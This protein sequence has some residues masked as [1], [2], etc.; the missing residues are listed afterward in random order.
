MASALM[1]NMPPHANR[2]DRFRRDI[3]LDRSKGDRVIERPPLQPAYGRIG[4]AFVADR[5]N[6]LLP[7]DTTEVDLLRR[8]SLDGLAAQIT[9]AAMR[10]KPAERMVVLFQSY[11][12]LGE[13]HHRLSPTLQARVV[14]RHRRHLSDA[15]TDFAGREHG[16]WFGV[17]WEGINFVHPT[18]R[19]TMVNTLIITRMP[20]APRDEI[21]ALRLSGVFN[22]PSRAE[23]VAFFE[24]L[25]A[26]YR[27]LYHG[28]LLGIRNEHDVIDELWILD[29]R[30]P[31]PAYVYQRQPPQIIRA[32]GGLFAYYDRIVEPYTINQWFKVDAA[33]EVTPLIQLDDAAD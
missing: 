23:G 28:L 19:R 33:G 1:T 30:W 13:V 10:R 5:V 4:S 14:M 9:T 12:A 2:Y 7:T 32:I 31:L 25:H 24:S 16:I 29:P 20:L 17:E 21:R 18:T 27:K 15:M 11:T 6:A 3:D 26:A 8:S 22:D